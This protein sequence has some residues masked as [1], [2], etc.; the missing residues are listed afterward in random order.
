MLFLKPANSIENAYFVK[1]KV[2]LIKK[3]RSI[4]K[5][6]KLYARIKFTRHT[7]EYYRS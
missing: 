1:R 5:I 2:D 3:M 4:S 6:T 7:Q